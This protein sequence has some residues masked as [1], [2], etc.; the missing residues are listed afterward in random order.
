M[1]LAETIGWIMCSVALLGGLTLAIAG[2]LASDL[3]ECEVCRRLEA[4]Q[5]G[6][7]E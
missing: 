5:N 3:C 4:M 2:M 7:D 6:A 1:T